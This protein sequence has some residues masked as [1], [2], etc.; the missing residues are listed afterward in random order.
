MMELPL[1]TAMLAT[2]LTI[3]FSFIYG[4]DFLVDR[5]MGTIN[6]SCPF[7]LYDCKVLVRSVSWLSNSINYSR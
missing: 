3:T 2:A 1:S 4:R 7:P 5:L 6:K